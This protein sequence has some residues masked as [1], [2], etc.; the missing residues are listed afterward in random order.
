VLKKI[1]DHLE[2]AAGVILLFFMCLL[3]FVNVITRYFINYSFAFTEEIEVACLVWVS[4]LGASQGFKLGIHLGFELI[5]LRF[6]KVGKKILFPC[7]SLLA[8][9]S[10]SVLIYYSYFQMKEEILLKIT[11]EA[12]SIPQWIYTLAIPV[13]GILMIV[14]IIEVMVKRLKEKG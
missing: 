13:G 6:P 11:T 2:E 12:L 7:A 3:A 10:I 14:R 8:I 5:A 4:M 1:F 9:F